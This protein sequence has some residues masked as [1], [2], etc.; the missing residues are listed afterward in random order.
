MPGKKDYILVK[1]DE[2]RIHVQKRLVLGNL[3]GVYSEFK[4]RFHDIFRGQ[5]IKWH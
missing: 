1:V 5:N 3:R 4:Q 2:K